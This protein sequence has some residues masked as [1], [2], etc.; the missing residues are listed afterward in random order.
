M[1]FVDTSALYAVLD[2]NDEVHEAALST[3][4]DLLSRASR[5]ALLT[6]NYVLVEAFALIQARLGLEAVHTFHDDMLPVLRLE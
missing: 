6:S 5:P 3:R 1:I 4:T 2:R